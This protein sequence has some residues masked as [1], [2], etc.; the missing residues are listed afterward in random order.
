[1][2]NVIFQ[3]QELTWDELERHESFR[4]AEEPI[5]AAGAGLPDAQAYVFATRADFDEWAAEAGVADRV[6][7]VTHKAEGLKARKATF[8]DREEEEIRANAQ[9][10]KRSLEEHVRRTGGRLASPETLQRWVEEQA[11]EGRPIDPFVGWDRTNYTGAWM[12]FSSGAPRL[13]PW[14]D[15]LSSIMMVS[16]LGMFCEHDWLGG[17]K[18][19]LFGLPFFGF[20]DLGTFALRPGVTWDKQISSFLLFGW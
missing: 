8:T 11:A 14:N 3:G 1:V 13:G 16:A 15:W 18:L 20:P 5:T 19:W 4:R 6:E 7:A 9:R 17:A 12:L 10:L 2:K